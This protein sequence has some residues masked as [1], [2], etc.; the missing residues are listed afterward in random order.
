MAKIPKFKFEKDEAAFWDKHTAV[1]F[2]DELEE[3]KTEFPKPRKRPISLWMEEGRIQALKHIA[4]SK[5]I[6]YLTLVRMWVVERL[7][8]EAAQKNLLPTT[9]KHNI[10]AKKRCVPIVF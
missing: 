2:L 3:V 7:N 4:G 10:A 8:S 5:G 1:E 9:P 6:G